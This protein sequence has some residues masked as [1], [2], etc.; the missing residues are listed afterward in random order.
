LNVLKS[1]ISNVATYGRMAYNVGG[2]RAQEKQRRAQC[3]WLL[4]AWGDLVATQ[5]T[6]GTAVSV[7][8]IWGFT[9]VRAL[10]PV[11]L[12]SPKA[13][14]LRAL[15]SNTFERKRDTFT[16]NLRA[17]AVSGAS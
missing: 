4:P 7:F 1:L 12:L 5:R 17:T 2:L 15:A 14:H 6:P 11:L 3:S 13:T 10:R 9:G 8:L 16:Y